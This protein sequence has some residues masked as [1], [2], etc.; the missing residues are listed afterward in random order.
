MN[1]EK[2]YVIL[3]VIVLIVIGIAFIFILL[4]TNSQKQNEINYNSQTYPFENK[5]IYLTREITENYIHS[6][7]EFSI[8]FPSNW[9]GNVETRYYKKEDEKEEKGFG[10]GFFLKTE[11]NPLILV[12]IF[13][14]QTLYEAK[15]N[16]LLKPDRIIEKNDFIYLI[17]D[18]SD[19][20]YFK[21]K[22]EVNKFSKDIPSIIKTIKINN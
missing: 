13:N 11:E 6:E 17:Y 22:T 19:L 16:I 12:H 8:E 2:K 14:S 5:S 4:S 9:V 1:I 18:Y 15:K 3:S 10:V 21:N 7:K 20:E